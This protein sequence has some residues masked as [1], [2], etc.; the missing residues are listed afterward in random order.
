MTTELNRVIDQVSREKGLEKENLIKTLEEAVKT[1]AK[2]KLGPNYD[3]EVSFNEEIG[4]IEVFEFKEVVEEVQDDHLEI[5][6]EEA[7]KIDPECEVGDS[8]GIKMDTD[9]FGRIAAQSAKQVIMQRLREA[10]RNIVFDDFK[11]RRGEIVHGIVQRFD[12]GSIIVNLGR[13]EAEL[14]PKEQIPKESYKQGDRIRAYI[15]DV[16]QYSRGPQI[17]LSRTHPNFLSALFENEVPE[18]S[19]GIVSIV[20]VAR[21][22][23]SRA[24][25]AVTSRDSDVDPVGACVGMKGTRVQ[26]VVQELR[27]E[28]IDIVTWDPD[29]AKFICN[30]L[31]PAEITRVIVDEDNR[32]MEVVVPDDQLS[33]AIGKKGQNV[34]LASRLSGWHLD[35]TSE[36]EYNRSLKEAY[37][38]LLKIDGVGEKTAL[39]LYQAGYRSFEEMA[40][41]DVSD[42]VQLKD[43]GEEKA[44]KIIQS[45]QEQLKR[46]EAE[47]AKKEAESSA[48]IGEGEEAAF[49]GQSSE[50][51]SGEIANEEG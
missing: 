39:T 48:E 25:I 27:G 21:E 44:L 19:E 8:L 34:R 14:P 45:A 2:K 41:A 18:I 7:R 15:L 31:A 5:S 13:T 10:E 23:G 43:I 30:A 33:L 6:L 22:P 38:S 50:G 46:E 35:V 9:E 42:L 20:Q 1:A 51:A 11:D 49:S 37:E 16:R 4:E 36:T 28:K 29:A 17:I 24:K 12:K 40:K 3:L 47:A 26:A 32:S